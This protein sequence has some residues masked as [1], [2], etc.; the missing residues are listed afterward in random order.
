MQERENGYFL[1]DD[2]VKVLFTKR[3]VDAKSRE[4][5]KKICEEYDFNYNNLAFNTQVHGAKVRIIKSKEEL[6]NNG[7]DADGLVTSL[8]KTPLLI[9]TADCV[10]LVFYDKTQRV[11]AL[12]HAGWRGT[13]DNIAKEIVEI[14]V[15]NYYSK[16]E[17]IKVIIGPSVSGEN[18]E[19]SKELI[20]KFSVHG[21]ADYY[22]KREESY[23]LDLWAVNK[24]LLINTGVLE[25]NIILMNLC[26]VRDNDKFFSYR[27]DKQTQKRIGTFIELK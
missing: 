10:P 6:A 15:E 11:V 3:N 4:D 5:V 20:E 22:K 24:G 19:V 14:L 8:E 18:Y 2:D 16:V 26:T 17:D 7:S 21:I 13:Y 27:L 23:Y 25:E 1:E 9:F 12:A